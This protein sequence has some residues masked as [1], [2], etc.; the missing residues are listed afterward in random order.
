M[1]KVL[2]FK[3]SRAWVATSNILRMSL[4]VEPPKSLKALKTGPLKNRLSKAINM[5]EQAKKM[6]KED[7]LEKYSFAT[8]FKGKWGVHPDSDTDEDQD[9]LPGSNTKLGKKHETK[10]IPEP[11]KEIM[12][13]KKKKRTKTTP[14]IIRPDIFSDDDE[15]ASTIVSPYKL[16]PKRNGIS[17]KEDRSSES[18]NQSESDSSSHEQEAGHSDHEKGEESDEKSSTVDEAKLEEALNYPMPEMYEL[19][20]EKAKKGKKAGLPLPRKIKVKLETFLM[21]SSD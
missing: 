1:I 9:D 6:R 5:A 21:T 8:L 16:Q 19:H 20:S 4:P 7:R 17:Q 2:L 12:L 15:D 10:A 18:E 13:H 14:K 3:V 11:R